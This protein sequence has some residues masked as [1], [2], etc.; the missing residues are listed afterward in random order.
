MRTSW[1]PAWTIAST[2]GSV[3]QRAV[4][5]DHRTRRSDRGRPRP[6]VRPRMRLASDATTC[7]GVDD[8]PHLDA[9]GRTAV[10]GRDDAVLR[11][12]DQTPRQVARVGGLER[13][14]G[15]AL[16]RA[17]RRVEVLEHRQ[18]F[19]EV[20]DDRALDDLAR[21][22]RHQAAHAGELT[23]LRRRTAR[24]GMRHH[25]DRVDR[26]IALAVGVL[27]D[28]RDLFHHLGSAISSVAFDQASTTLLYFS[29]WVIRPSL[30]CCSNS[31][32]SVLRRVDDLPLRGRHHHV[33]LAERDAGLERVEEAERHD[34]IAEDHR[35]LL[36]AVAIDGGRSYWRFRAS[37]SAC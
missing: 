4:A 32:A 14:V 26:P 17:V 22:L 28:R 29:P 33:V 20:R 8:G 19:L 23:H 2:C 36:T 1:T 9:G 16:A 5:H 25:V 27:L 3:E 24:S 35:L 15:E 11:H 37:S 18:A 34:A 13:R 6:T 30:N 21:R 7:A 10:L 12:V 31:L